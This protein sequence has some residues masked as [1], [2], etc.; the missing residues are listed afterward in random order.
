[1]IVETQ[2]TPFV[3]RMTAPWAWRSERKIATKLMGFAATEHGSALDMMRAAERTR[4]ARLR[5]LFYRHAL[6]EARH[7][8][9]FRE[10]ATRVYP[11]APELLRAHEKMHAQ[12]MDLHE[13]L[14]E[15]GFIAFV[16]LAESRAKRQFE[17][18]EEYF[19]GRP[20]KEDLAAL[21]R[22]I[23]K[24][25]HHH[26]AYSRRLLDERREA[27]EGAAVRRAIRRVKLRSAWQAWRRAGKR[28]GDVMVRLLLIA[29]F[30]SV[31]PLFAI[32]GGRA[33]PRTGWI[34]ESD[35]EVTIANLE[36]QA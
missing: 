21:F 24:D 29:L 16:W 15:L 10:V 13:R 32:V 34:T 2:R 5:R 17:A 4:D 33:K 14:G 31:V 23:G 3:M 28:V 30:V 26:S 22:H 7:A 8:Q 6:D 36:R 18:L 12:R 1:M 11:G 25:E 27:G 19:A 20:D 9:L 35:R